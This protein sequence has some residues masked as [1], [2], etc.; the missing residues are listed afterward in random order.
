MLVA[1]TQRGISLFDLNSLTSIPVNEDLKI[2][3]EIEDLIVIDGVVYLALGTGGVVGLNVGGLIDSGDN[4]S[5]QVVQIKKINMK[6]VKSSG[7]E[8]IISKPLNAKFLADSKP[9]LLVSGEKNDLS[10]IRVS[11]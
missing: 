1:S 3:N 6:V 7:K 8:D 11:P 5:A 2:K 9:F 4:N 10:V